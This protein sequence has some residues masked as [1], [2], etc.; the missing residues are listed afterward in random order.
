MK[1]SKKILVTGGSGRFGEIL[2]KFNYKN[3]IFPSKKQLDITNTK[4]I[5]KF[6]LKV[7]PKAIIHLAGLSR[8][9]TM[10]EKDPIKSIKLNI[11][12]T[13]NLVIAANRTY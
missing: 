11:I 4:S 6:I 10:H 13:C 12:G 1:L 3:Y 5:K 8:P 2:K 9:L 7:K